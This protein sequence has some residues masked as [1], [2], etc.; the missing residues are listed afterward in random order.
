MSLATEVYVRIVTQ[1]RDHGFMLLVGFEPRIVAATATKI[2]T[3][4]APTRSSINYMI[5]KV[6]KDFNATTVRD[7]TADGILRQ[8][9]K[10]FNEPDPVLVAKREAI[11]DRVEAAEIAG[12]LPQA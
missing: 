6:K 7:I 12:E 4:T 9:R 3:L 2:I 5:E 8:L 11:I 1:G 10:L